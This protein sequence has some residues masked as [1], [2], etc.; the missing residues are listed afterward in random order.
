M[1]EYEF[2]GAV[3]MPIREAGGIPMLIPHNLSGL[4]QTTDSFSSLDKYF[5]TTSGHIKHGSW[6]SD[7]QPRQIVGI[8]QYSDEDISRGPESISLFEFPSSPAAAILAFHNRTKGPEIGVSGATVRIHEG[9]HDELFFYSGKLFIPTDLIED[10]DGEG[11]NQ[12]NSGKDSAMI[13]QTFNEN[14]QEYMDRKRKTDL[15]D[16]DLTTNIDMVLFR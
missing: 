16:D 3:I 2:N 7:N 5:V 11:I 10:Y 8:L 9:E 4:M 15:S 6:S 12:L 13:Y 1:V 14:L